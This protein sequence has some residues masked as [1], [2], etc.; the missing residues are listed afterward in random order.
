MLLVAGRLGAAEPSA[1]W[2]IVYN[3]NEPDSPA[4]AQYYAAKR[5]LPATHLVGLRVRNAES[6][7]RK[8]FVEQIRDPLLK[9]LVDR[10]WLM[11]VGQRETIDNQITGL[12]LIYGIPLRIEADATLKDDALP[13]L[14]EPG[15]RNH[16]AVDSELALLPAPAAPLTGWVPNPFFRSRG[17]DFRAPLNNALL[18]VARLDGPDA[19]TA[20]RLVDD[21]LA[22]ER[23]GLLG[24]CYFDARGL[25]DRAYAIGDQWIKSA[26]RAFR[27]AGYE[28]ELD[29]AGAMF[30]DDFPMSDAAVYAGWY[31]GH[32]TGPFTQ[33]AFQFRRGAVAVHIHS[34]SAATV[35]SRSAHWVGPLLA[36]GVAASTGNVFEPY[37]TL[38]PHLDLFFKRLLDGAPYAEAG[39]F[40]QPVLSWQTTFVGD[41]LYRPFAVPVDE[42]IT[43][44][45]VAG[46]P[47]LEWAY[48]RQVNLLLNAGET[49]AA[50][51]LCRTQ[52]GKLKSPVLLEKLGDLLPVPDR[53][54]A[55]ESALRSA[56]ASA[57]YLRVAAKL[58]ATFEANHQPAQAAAVYEGLLA[59]AT[60]K[61]NARARALQDKI[62]KLKAPPQKEPQPK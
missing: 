13:N 54:A 57:R 59:S 62:D 8:E 33:P 4:L 15:R 38:T 19:A 7:T 36:K 30:D 10:G 48:L 31:G 52:A 20:R 25:T 35:R 14:P 21:A 53:A 29:E 23:F 24:R 50:V 49:N 43:R 16:A 44:L 18:L 9:L 61:T 6:I 58:A 5:H 17:P 47:D 39:W 28:C 42:Q 55:Y 11:Q 56:G 3:E 12:V 60:I 51:Q 45:A 26:D 41:P 32:P 1:R 2:L 46:H 40:S 34:G 27:A 22:A 37:L